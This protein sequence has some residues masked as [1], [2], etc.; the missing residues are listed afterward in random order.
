MSTP[1]SQPSSGD[2]LSVVTATILL[3]YATSRF[4]N[5]P[6]RTLEIQLP[7]LYLPA[8]FNTNVVVLLL[9]AALTA[10][11][12]E[13]LIRSHPAQKERNTWQHWLLPALTA[14]VIGVP[15]FQL[16]PG[17]AW[18]LTFG[19]GG[20]L[21]FL[22]L[23]AEYI[24][25][26]PADGRRAIAV[27]ALTALAFA[28]YLMLVVALRQVE[29]R[30]FLLLIASVPT[31]WLITLRSLHLRTGR[32]LFAS[33]LVVI[34]I[35]GQ[36]LSALHYLPLL[37]LTFGL[38]LLGPAYALTILVGNLAEGTPFRQAFWEPLFVLLLLW[39]IAYWV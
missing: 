2:R 22:V 38:A 23:A 19:L 39:G 26:D 37:P 29:V 30:L 16:P 28:L 6:S 12:T 24:V 5:F 21:L 20:L 9:V 17:A 33:S 1:R 4:I 32:W 13:W 31:Q 18:W 35:I 36:Y 25:V 14:W 10:L 27:P 8:Q 34:V 15:L 11:G 7:G 3:A